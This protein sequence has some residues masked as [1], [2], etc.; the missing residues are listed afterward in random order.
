MQMVPVTQPGAFNAQMMMVYPGMPGYM[1]GYGYHHYRRK[2]KK[3]KKH[4]KKKEESDSSS[5][6]DSDYETEYYIVQNNSRT[7]YTCE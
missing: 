7:P 4:K 6:S 3:H 1:P 2:C 5:D